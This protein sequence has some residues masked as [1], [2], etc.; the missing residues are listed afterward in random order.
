MS[1]TTSQSVVIFSENGRY[2]SLY[3]CH[4]HANGIYDIITGNFNQVHLYDETEI[5]P[6][7]MDDVAG[8]ICTKRAIYLDHGAR[9]LLC[10]ECCGMFLDHTHYVDKLA[11]GSFVLNKI[12]DGDNGLV[13]VMVDSLPAGAYNFYEFSED[14]SVCIISNYYMYP[15][16]PQPSSPAIVL[17]YADPVYRFEPSDQTIIQYMRPDLFEPTEENKYLGY[18]TGIPFGT[19]YVNVCTCYP[20]GV[21]KREHFVYCCPKNG[22]TITEST[23]N[24]HGNSSFCP[25]QSQERIYYREK[26]PTIVPQYSTAAV[27]R[28]DYRYDGK[29]LN[30][31][32]Y[33]HTGKIL[34]RI[35]EELEP[36]DVEF[37][38]T[39]TRSV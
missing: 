9:S 11:D 5:E 2:V 35:S 18:P 24:D 8:V 36:I 33:H 17:D 31:H 37:E 26:F 27:N 29:R 25:L 20:S 4:S 21:P 6:I 16:D 22:V 10:T 19:R 34:R 23:M 13:G 30:R 14:A 38:T 1:V 12:V 39:I 3:N 32:I 15:E 28:R 7:F